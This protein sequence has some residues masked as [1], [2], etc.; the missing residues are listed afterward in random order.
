MPILQID[1]R[2][3]VRSR[4]LKTVTVTEITLTA[5][6]TTHAQILAALLDLPLVPPDPD[7]AWRSWSG[8]VPDLSAQQPVLVTVTAPTPLGEA[9]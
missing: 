3:T 4:G 8:R 6:T 5:S 7:V 2:N 1:A 9:R